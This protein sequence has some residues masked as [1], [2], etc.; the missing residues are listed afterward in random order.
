MPEPLESCLFFKRSD[1]HWLEPLVQQ[2]NAV[3]PE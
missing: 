3:R 1:L 2:L